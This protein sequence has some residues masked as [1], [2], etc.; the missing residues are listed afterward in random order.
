MHLEG[1]IE[2]D[3]LAISD[4]D[5]NDAMGYGM[6]IPDESVYKEVHSLLNNV[7][8]KIGRAHV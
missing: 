2:F 5:L 8:S 7:A 4:A 6:A 1:K 3:K